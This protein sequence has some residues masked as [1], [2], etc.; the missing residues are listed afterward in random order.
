MD[1][2]A[3]ARL[4]LKHVL[5]LRHRRIARI[6]GSSIRPQGAAGWLPRGYGARGVPEAG[7]V[8][9]FSDFPE[10]KGCRAA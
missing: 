9:I 5:E 3:G 1:R 4:A 10:E 8:V 6:A 2:Q 7:Q